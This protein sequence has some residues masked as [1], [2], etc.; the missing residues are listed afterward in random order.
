MVASKILVL[1]GCATTLP[2]VLRDAA[3]VQCQ[4]LSVLP[5]PTELRHQVSALAGTVDCIVGADVTPGLY[6]LAAQ[7][8]FPDARVVVECALEA[9]GRGWF[10]LHSGEA[11]AEGLQAAASSEAPG[12]TRRDGDQ[13]QPTTRPATPVAPG[14]GSV[15]AAPSARKPTTEARVGGASRL[16]DLDDRALLSRAFLT[17]A[18]G[19]QAEAVRDLLEEAASR[20][21]VSPGI[22]KK[23]RDNAKTGD[24]AAK[25]WQ[26]VLEL[27]NRTSQGQGD[28]DA[29]FARILGE[30]K[31]YLVRRHLEHCLQKQRDFVR[32][33]VRH[34]ATVRST[35]P[36]VEL[37]QGV[38]PNSLRHL[39]ANRHWDVL[40]DESGTEFGPQ[41][42]ALPLSDSTLGRVVA[43]AVPTG[44]VRLPPL[45]RGF[46][47]A[48]AAP[49]AVD[50]AIASVLNSGVGLFGFTLKDRARGL[51]RHW[52]SA[53][54]T[55]MRWVLRQLPLDT[56]GPAQVSVEGGPSVRFLIERREDYE[57]GTSLTVLCR[58]LGAELA[59]LDDR[60]A[61]LNISAGFIAKDQ[62]PLNGYVDAV[63]YTWGSASKVSKDR[64]KKSRLKGHCLLQPDDFAMERLYLTLD[65]HLELEPRQWYAL[66][67]RLQGEPLGSLAVELAG[68]LGE[69]IRQDAGAWHRLLAHVEGLLQQ[70]RYVLTE[71]AAALEWLGTWVP[72]N[73]ELPPLARLHWHSARLACANHFGATSLA[74]ATRAIELA[75]QLREEVGPDACDADLR[76]AVAATNAFR[77]ELAA[78]ALHPWIGTDPA[79]PGLR[80]WCKVQSS[81][82]Q[83]AAFLGEY[84][85]A[86]GYLDAALAGFAR[87]HDRR[88]A[89]RESGQ[90]QAYRLIVR[91]DAVL[92]ENASG[93]APAGFSE[94]LT[95]YLG[96]EVERFMNGAR[97]AD[98]VYRY[99]HHVLL[100]SLVAFPES[101]SDQVKRYLHQ[102]DEWQSGKGH[103]WP[104][105]DAYRALLLAADGHLPLAVEA[106][107]RAV[108]ALASEEAPLLRW[109]HCVLGVALGAGG[110]EVT[111]GEDV[112]VEEFEKTLPEAPHTA[113]N[114]WSNAVAGGVRYT[115][116]EIMVE[117]GTCL[118][119]NFH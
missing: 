41:S 62:H 108:D 31:H 88:A 32:E 99:E 103:P 65:R 55:M 114:D 64:L 80:N 61:R 2:A 83:H 109:M 18:W 92:R 98:E 9:G 19:N 52:M 8:V 48:E 105:I 38:H 49:E 115:L 17:S 69:R 66:V 6:W 74:D 42:A 7:A 21:T 3:I 5:A 84:E 91:M 118:P 85:E 54:E 36:V 72:V 59:E 68:R 39:P 117:L 89:K 95:A 110:V 93:V 47:A 86:I 116:P 33:K 107:R 87:L 14:V 97:L 73:E 58:I 70:K 106:G 40:I 56:E 12:E 25:V 78:K 76:V 30:Q 100:R 63:A 15:A 104:L 35:L 24:R 23:A 22:L 60:F 26:T 75:G 111:W 90:T 43:L 82:G 77:F 51:D 13:M 20:E 96:M 28:F 11:V 81:L 34:V 101:F 1:P 102:A 29:Q 4:A 112:S 53:I 37:R 79:I 67:T 44:R 46:H 94:E 57:P 16:A 27:F 50:K 119:F 113:L 45:Q 10:D 71:L